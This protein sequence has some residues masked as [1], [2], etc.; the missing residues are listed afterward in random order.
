MPWWLRQGRTSNPSA[1][2]PEELQN[3]HIANWQ[4]TQLVPFLDKA[5]TYLGWPGPKNGPNN[6]EVP[7][8]G[9]RHVGHIFWIT[10]H[11]RPPNVAYILLQ[12]SQRWGP[13]LDPFIA[14]HYGPQGYTVNVRD[15]SQY[16]LH[17]LISR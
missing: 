3:H 5:L 4:N 10:S 2:S 8:F 15:S 17:V 11:I 9:T 12:V 6:V 13:I 7:R 1:P 16:D 14:N